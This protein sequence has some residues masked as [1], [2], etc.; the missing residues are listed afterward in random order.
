M[1][2][3]LT[4]QKKEFSGAEIS[5]GRT[6]MGKNLYDHD[7]ATWSTSMGAVKTKNGVNIR[8]ASDAAGITWL[9]EIIPYDKSY[10]LSY[11][12]INTYGGL[13]SRAVIRF[14]DKDGNN[15]SSSHA[16]KVYNSSDKW[17]T[18][19]QYY[20]G[21]YIDSGVEKKDVIINYK[22]E[23][24]IVGFRIAFVA[25]GTVGEYIDYSD[26]QIEEGKAATELEPFIRET[27]PVNAPMDL[28]IFGNSYQK[29][30]EQG[31]NLL[32]I[33]KYKVQYNPEFTLEDGVLDFTSYTWTHHLYYEIK[34]LTPSAKY[35]FSCV[36]NRQAQMDYDDKSHSNEWFAAT[37]KNSDGTYTAIQTM[38]AK[39]DGS[40]IIRFRYGQD[41]P[42]FYCKAWD[43]MLEPGSS[44]TTFEPF[45][46]NSPSKKY[47]SA[48][49]SS[50]EMLLKSVGIK[51]LSTK[52][53]IVG[54]AMEVTDFA[55]SNLTVDGKYYLA[56]YIEYNSATN[57][58]YRHKFIDETLFDNTLPIKDQIQVILEEPI[59][60]KLTP[61]ETEYLFKDVKS[62][63][64]GFVISMEN[65]ATDG[66]PNPH[67][68]QLNAKVKIIK[69]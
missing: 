32:D 44:K 53:P 63:Q 25:V 69:G 50:K 16:A 23:T 30:T 10:T 21:I 1:K 24:N 41:D 64:N 48:I 54:N 18:Y 42:V 37:T 47:P 39:A 62:I 59:V 40:L 4:L 60:E 49:Y 14:I 6:P 36:S 5:V 7:K 17:G 31:K 61:T 8:I 29:V 3:E 9:D 34:G 57:K 13:A 43:L 2:T 65:Y 35:T 33:T 11:T 20:A 22:A 19:N 52:I 46:P 68:L 66:L 38:I 56:D 58:A 67:P 27:Y 51:T 55:K 45:V 26:I 12:S 28:K 15:V